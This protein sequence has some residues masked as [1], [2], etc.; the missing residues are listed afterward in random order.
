A[1]PMRIDLPG[2]AFIRFL[3]R[4][5]RCPADKQHEGGEDDQEKTPQADCKPESPLPSPNDRH[6]IAPTPK[7]TRRARPRCRPRTAARCGGSVGP[8]E[9]AVVVINLHVIDKPSTFL[10]AHQK[11]VLG[12]VSSLN[13]G[14]LH[15]ENNVPR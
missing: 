9:T 11:P 1:A 2:V 13:V 14:H 10:L 6:V 3:Q 5:R 8:L 12:G 7:T 4:D 15:L